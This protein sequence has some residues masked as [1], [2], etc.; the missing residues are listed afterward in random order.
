MKSRF[1]N[2]KLEL[3]TSAFLYDYTNYLTM[4]STSTIIDENWNGVRDPWEVSSTRDP[5]GSMNGSIA[6]YGLDVMTSTLITPKDKLDLSI[7]YLK[8]EFDEMIFDYWD[9]TN[10][11]GMPDFNA[12][13]MPKT[14][15]PEWTVSAAYNH[16]FSL[17]NGGTLTFRADT[18]Y[19]TDYLIQW[20]TMEFDWADDMSSYTILDLSDTVRQEK[21]AMSNA[22]L[23]YAHPEGKYTLTG[24]VKNIENYAAKLSYMGQGGNLVITDPRTWGFILSVNY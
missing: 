22:S 2:D 15:S 4:M 11:L 20:Q 9:I 13:G 24:Y 17:Q 1:F 8:G 3:N 7:S 23:V 18:K 10:S 12:E 16:I 21:Y 19:T 5:N 6:V 14:N